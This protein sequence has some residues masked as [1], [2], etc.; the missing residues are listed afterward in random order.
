MLKENQCTYFQQKPKTNKQTPFSNFSTFMFE[1]TALR[2]WS[3][4]TLIVFE[5][6]KYTTTKK[7]DKKKLPF[8]D[9]ELSRKDDAS[10]VTSLELNY[11]ASVR[12][13][14]DAVEDEEEERGDNQ[15]EAVDMDVVVAAVILK[16]TISKR[17]LPQSKTQIK[18]L[19]VNFH[20]L[21]VTNTN[22]RP[23]YWYWILLPLQVPPV[24]ACCG[25]CSACPACSSPHTCNCLCKVSESQTGLI[26]GLTPWLLIN[27]FLNKLDKLGSLNKLALHPL[28]PHIY[29][30]RKKRILLPLHDFLWAPTFLS[31]C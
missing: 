15:E 8:T 9:S 26:C 6:H 4:L 13:P 18:N 7:S 16:H 30:W 22:L 27:G 1:C 31:V 24:G 5:R 21:Q 3:Y 25:S 29:T 20:L 14:V 2:L 17:I 10:Q 19:F 11:F 23:R 28:H 12:E